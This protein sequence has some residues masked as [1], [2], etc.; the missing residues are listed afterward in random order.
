MSILLNNTI[1]FGFPYYMLWVGFP[2]VAHTL[3]PLNW[4]AEH[5]VF[6]PAPGPGI[7][8]RA[9]LKMPDDSKKLV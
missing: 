7:L 9:E 2:S 5:E 6:L 3:H 4:G 8:C 1:F